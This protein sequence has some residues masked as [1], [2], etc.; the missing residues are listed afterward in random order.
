MNP[1][2][3]DWKI[4]PSK[5]LVLVRNPVDTISAAARYYLGKRRGRPDTMLNSLIDSYRYVQS[6]LRVRFSVM[7]MMTTLKEVSL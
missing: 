2:Q 6:S 3:L 7:T 4:A 1:S 5:L